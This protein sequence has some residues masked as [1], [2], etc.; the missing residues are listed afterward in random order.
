MSNPNAFVAA[1]TGLATTGLLWI[2][3]KAGWHLSTQTAALVAGAIVTSVTTL[4]LWIG[5]A[6]L[7]GAWQRVWSGASAV[8]NGPPAKK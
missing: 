3:A 2:G 6:G 4:F 5:R 1:L 7:K 8:V